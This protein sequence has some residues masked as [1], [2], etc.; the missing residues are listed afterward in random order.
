MTAVEV[1]PPREE[2]DPAAGEQPE[3][4]TALG[5]GA[6]AGT[7]AV[8]GPAA[9]L[10]R[11]SRE[12]LPAPYLIGIWALLSLSALAL[13]G[14]SYV[15]L[16]SSTQ[17][18]RAQHVLVASFRSTIAD[19]TA[20]VGGK[21]APGTPVALLTIPKLGL[22]DVAVIEGTTSTNLESGPGH[23]RDTP[24][25]GAMGASFIL[26]RSA[27][28]GAPFA[29]IA[30][31]KT[32]DDVKVQTGQGKFT[33]KVD[34]VRRPGDS[35]TLFGT[36]AARLTLV[37]SEPVKGGARQVLYVDATTTTGVK[38]A[39]SGLPTAIPVAE[40]Q[41]QSDRRGLAQAVLWLGA[42]VLITLALGW[43]RVRWGLGPTLV[44]AA[45]VL[46]TAAWLVSESLSRLLP[47][48]Y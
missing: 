31:L 41:L 8:P 36:A 42:L 17:E 28:F 40:K 46:A 2:E 14:A 33:F 7:G 39:P 12:R 6:K 15:Y 23:R 26:G 48:L 35:L 9:P 3:A 43:T 5:G 11:R 27:T 25:P 19:G 4:P 13:W 30:D 22:R 1:E 38:P 18:H 47:N 21:I 34:G 10:P 29:H 45:P 44:V 16:L 20:P 37:T 32:G 24:L